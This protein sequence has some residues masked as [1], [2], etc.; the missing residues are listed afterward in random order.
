MLTLNI[1]RMGR[2]GLGVSQ[3]HENHSCVFGFIIYCFGSMICFLAEATRAQIHVTQLPPMIL[4]S[5]IFGKERKR[6]PLARMLRASP[7]ERHPTRFTCKIGDVIL[8]W[9]MT[10][11][12]ATDPVSKLEYRYFV[13]KFFNQEHELVA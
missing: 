4:S 11:L 3:H 7:K 8:I 2:W 10:F 5:G 9:Q 12:M 6:K 13:Y 1:Y